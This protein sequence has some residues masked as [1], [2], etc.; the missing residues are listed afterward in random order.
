M[1]TAVPVSTKVRHIIRWV[2]W[3]LVLHCIFDNLTSPD[4]TFLPYSYWCLALFAP[5]IAVPS[6]MLPTARTLNQRRLYI[7]LNMAVLVLAR[8]A[9][10]GTSGLTSLV[11]IKA[12]LLLP[13]LEVVATAVIGYGLSLGHLAWMLPTMA[14]EFRT[15]DL[16]IY[17]DLQNIF[18][19]TAVSIVVDTTFVMLLGFVFAAEQRSRR[20][21][22]RLAIE[23]ESLAT[24][25]ERS[26][27]ARDIH[28]SLGHSLTALDIQ[29]SLAER[30]SYSPGSH[31][32]LQTTLTKSKQLAAQCLA[33][34]RQSLQTMRDTSFDLLSA[35]R[36]VSDQMRPSFLV[37]LQVE[38]PPLPQ[39]LSYQF[40]LIAKEGL[41]NVQK[42]AAASKVS[43]SI[44]AANDQIE[45][46]LLDNGRGFEPDVERSGYGLQGIEE[47]SH[48]LGG[49]M[50][51]YSRLG[52]GTQL[53]VV[54]P[55]IKAHTEAHTDSLKAVSK[56]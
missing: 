3:L 25:L 9:R 39:Q 48:L 49:K 14:D 44:M 12:C 19:R 4:F 6:F 8:F 10:I 53:Q 42:H 32:K 16:E 2:E 50:I 27:I 1:H 22:E 20:Q 51:I 29:I 56:S 52:Q 54:V 5:M 35:L 46:T 11:I 24:K 40:Y 47:R 17:L 33:E 41:V 55:L 7:A 43:L 18:T 31:P 26:R 36:T 23:V 15:R 45:L 30:Y 37:N 21:A 28:D 38:L 34:A 13:R